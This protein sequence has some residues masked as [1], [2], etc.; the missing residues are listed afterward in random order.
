MVDDRVGRVA[1]GALFALAIGFSNLGWSPQFSQRVLGAALG[2]ALA[3]VL[4]YVW[5]ERT[6]PKAGLI[7]WIL[8]IIVLGLG[9]VGGTSFA[10]PL[11][12][13]LFV[14]AFLCHDMR[15]TPSLMIAAAFAAALWQPGKRWA[16]SP[17]GDAWGIALAVLLGLVAALVERERLAAKQ[18]APMPLLWTGLR[19]GFLTVWTFGILSAKRDLQVGRFFASLG[20][21]P[22]RLEGQLFLLALIIVCLVLAGVIFRTKPAKKEPAAPGAPTFPQPR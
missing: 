17:E 3:G 16:T 9:V 1:T 20:V 10:L 19:V 15:L 4:A 21:D 18:G 13:G 12:L 2:L 22:A 14:G 5:G 6:R 11:T 8:G 7:W